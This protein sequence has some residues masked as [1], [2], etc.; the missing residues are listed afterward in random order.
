MKVVI[1]TLTYALK[2]VLLKL[3][4]FVKVSYKFDEK[5]LLLPDFITGCF[6]TTEHGI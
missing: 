3:F 4:C 5:E 2:F 1:I 6:V